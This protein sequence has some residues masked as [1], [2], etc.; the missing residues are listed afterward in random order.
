MLVPKVKAKEFARYGFK[1]CKGIPR[2]SECYYLCV[3]RGSKMIFV[4]D[5]CFDINDWKEEDPRI[6]KDANCRYR[7]NRTA[8]DI[9]YQ[10]VKDDMLESSFYKESGV[11]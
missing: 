11:E 5:I 3:A 7:D 1:R 10:L 2:D 4:S 6:H 8:L 9:L